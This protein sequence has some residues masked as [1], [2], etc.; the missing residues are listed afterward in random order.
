MNVCILSIFPEIFSGFLTQS[1]ISKALANSKFTIDIINIRNFATP[2]HNQVDD[3]PY[4]GGAGMVMKPEPLALAI[5]EAKKR[6]TKAK[7]ILMSPSGNL[8]NQE[9]AEQ[10]SQL[11]QIILIC[12]RYEGIDQRVIDIFVDHEI[13]IGDYVLMGGEVPAMA[14][15][16]ATLRLRENIIGNALSIKEESFSISKNGKRLL[17]APHY[18]RPQEFRGITVPEVLLSGDHKGVN[19]WR[20]NQALQKTEKRRPDLLKEPTK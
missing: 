6:Y 8:F 11:E 3:S 18:T 7:V 4:G 20:Y 16:E 17:E 14:V 19:N 13:S 5:E 15:I 2:P 10:L 12:G 1:L 9:K